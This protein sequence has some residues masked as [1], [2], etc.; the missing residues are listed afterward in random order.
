[1]RRPSY[2]VHK[3]R[4]K[5]GRSLAFNVRR[6]KN[7]ASPAAVGCNDRTCSFFDPLVFPQS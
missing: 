3:K 4:M 7:Y 6:E 1:M 5:L 2:R